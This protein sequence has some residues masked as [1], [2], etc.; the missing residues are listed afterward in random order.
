MCSWILYLLHS[1]P[2][3]LSITTSPQQLIK[4]SSDKNLELNEQVLSEL[5][6]VQGDIVVVTIVGYYRTGKSYLLNHLA[7][8]PSGISIVTRS[9]KSSNDQQTTTILMDLERN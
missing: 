9:D 7:G 8:K 1:F 3:A 6:K 4:I 5:R 2:Q